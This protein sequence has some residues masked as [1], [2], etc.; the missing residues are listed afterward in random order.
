MSQ[1]ILILFRSRLFS[2]N[3]SGPALLRS[4]LGNHRCYRFSSTPASWTTISCLVLKCQV[5]LHISL[6]VAP[7]HNNYVP[8]VTIQVLSLPRVAWPIRPKNS[9]SPLSFMDHQTS[10]Q[11][12]PQAHQTSL[13]STVINHYRRIAHGAA[14]PISD[15]NTGVGA[16]TD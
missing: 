5:R 14:R 4:L 3:H 15:A 13:I 8:F 10:G 11:H 6:S 2:S 16:G 1:P 9:Y 12:F 7:L